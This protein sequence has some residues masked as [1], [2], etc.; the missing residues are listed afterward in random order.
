MQ[1]PNAGGLA[2]Q[3]NIGFT[4]TIFIA[5]LSKYHSA[6]GCLLPKIYRHPRTHHWGTHIAVLCNAMKLTSVTPYHK[7]MQKSNM[8]VMIKAY[9]TLCV[10]FAF[11]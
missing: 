10:G 11:W 7:I 8:T 6:D 1:G 5:A 9:I 3:W 2:L 4:L